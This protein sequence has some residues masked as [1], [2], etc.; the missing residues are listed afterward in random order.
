[1]PCKVCQKDASTVEFYNSI[2]THCKEHWK[3]RVRQNRAANIEHYREFDRARAK[4]P[5]RIEAN[6]QYMQTPAGK[7]AHYRANERYRKTPDGQEVGRRSRKK[8]MATA[9]GR[10]T[11][12]RS[13]RRYLESPKGRAAKYEA[14]KRQRKKFPQREKARAAVAYA[15]RL[16]KIVSM[17]CLVCGEHAEAHHPDYS[18]P[19]DV[20]WLCD[21]HH[22]EVHALAKSLQQEPF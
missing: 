2:T 16:G 8:Y 21:T 22:K 1:M 9:S 3:E 11:H 7:A 13:T 17:P 15:I 6:R 4:L 19:L 18:R 20:V 10:E 14:T 5:H 12:Y